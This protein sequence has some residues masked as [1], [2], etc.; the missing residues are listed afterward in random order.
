MK[1]NTLDVILAKYQIAMN[2]RT[3]EGDLIWQRF[4]S[5]IVGHAILFALIG[6]FLTSD[7]LTNN[8]VYVRLVSGAG[9]ILSLLWLLSTIRG[10]ETLKYW[11]LCLREIEEKIP[12]QQYDVNLYLR[13]EKYF[14]NYETV[15]FN[16]GTS[17]SK[18]IQR[19]FISRKVDINT[20]WTAYFSIGL[21]SIA[22]LFIIIFVSNKSSHQDNKQF[23]NLK[24][25]IRSERQYDYYLRDKE[26]L[27]HL[28]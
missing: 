2:H 4:S 16:F 25:N 14:L 22:Y 8:Y 28:P 20:K 17:E 3:H 27:L 7:S 10:F 12:K 9:L 23:I 13:G 24:K 26:F 5:F 15:R 6:Q 19:S 11:T 18:S 1:N 21:I